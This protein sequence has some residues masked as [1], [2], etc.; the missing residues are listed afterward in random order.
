M[1]YIKD[2]HSKRQGETPG[3]K[4]DYTETQ[5]TKKRNTKKVDVKG[6]VDEAK[7]ALP[8]NLREPQN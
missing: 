8:K 2:Q 5:K 1:S 3:G 7:T 4:P 6:D